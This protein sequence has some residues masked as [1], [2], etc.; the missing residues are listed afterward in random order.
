MNSAY[1]F[2]QHMLLIFRDKYS[3]KVGTKGAWTGET[4]AEYDD[5]GI[6]ES[7]DPEFAKVMNSLG[8]K[9]LFPEEPLRDM[10]GTVS[11]CRAYLNTLT[12]YASTHLGKIMS[13]RDYE[14]KWLPALERFQEEYNRKVAFH[15]SPENWNKYITSVREDHYPKEVKA[16]CKKHK[17]SVTNL[18]E[19]DYLKINSAVDYVISKIPSPESIRMRHKLID[20]VTF[21]EGMAQLDP[22]SDNEVV[23][24]QINEMIQSVLLSDFQPVL[25]KLGRIREVYLEQ[26]K[27]MSG[28]LRKLIHGTQKADGDGTKE[29]GI[30]DM[31]ERVNTGGLRVLEDIKRT[32]RSLVSSTFCD[33]NGREENLVALNNISK[34]TEDILS[35]IHTS[36][37]DKLADSI[38]FI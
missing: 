6:D 11:R 10:K 23:I 24:R 15:T 25:Q 5:Y 14:T 21:I 2:R 1:E 31:I 17:I 7:E 35:A 16:Y 27:N 18:D 19:E 20:S 32:V 36:D 37:I 26:G 30:L 22:G 3:V 28:Q 34:K 38:E 33:G 4:K 12:K 29:D 13:V 9:S 8:R